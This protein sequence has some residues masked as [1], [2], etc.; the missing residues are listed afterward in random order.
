MT[1][2][3]NWPK[4]FTEE[5]HK[6]AVTFAKLASKTY[7]WDDNAVVKIGM[8]F[9]SGIDDVKNQD[10]STPS[11]RRKGGGGNFIDMIGGSDSGLDYTIFEEIAT[12]NLVLA[13]RGTE[14]LS[15]EDWRHDIKQVL[16]GER[17]GQYKAAIA[18]ALKMDAKAKASGIKLSFTGHSLGGGLASAAA[19][20]T[21]REA[22]VFCAAGL[23]TKTVQDYDWLKHSSN[24]L[25][26]NVQE[27]FV[28]DW[29]KEMDD[30][31]IGHIS[32]DIGLDSRQ[33]GPQ[34]WLKSVSDRA[35]FIGIP[36]HFSIVKTA[37]SVLN[38]AW[39]VFTFQLEHKQFA[40]KK[41]TKRS[42]PESTEVGVPVAKRARTY[43][44]IVSNLKRT[45]YPSL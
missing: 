26:V 7:D 21:G 36:D 29:N 41:E 2:I 14:P 13:F 45:E 4:D 9:F 8:A 40:K 33:Y 25:N 32:D 5:D 12:G 22:I 30:T 20:A 39:Q 3:A 17:D 23:S 31:T 6:R 10:F 24:I 15:L 11:Y 38:H 27:C 28:S 37:E 19:I 16:V 35:N 42:L 34:I 44:S 18:L 1:D 43:A